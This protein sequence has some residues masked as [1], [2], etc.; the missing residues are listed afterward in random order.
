MD[1]ESL[2]QVGTNAGRSRWNGRLRAVRRGL[3]TI[4]RFQIEV[5]IIMALLVTFSATTYVITRDQ[6]QS[7]AWGSTVDMTIDVY[8]VIDLDE[9]GTPDQGTFTGTITYMI[10]DEQADDQSGTLL[11]LSAADGF[12]GTAT[13]SAPGSG[14][15]LH[16]DST[17]M[18][19]TDSSQVQHT[20]EAVW[21]TQLNSDDCDVVAGNDYDCGRLLLEFAEVEPWLVLTS[22]LVNRSAETGEDVLLLSSVR[23]ATRWDCNMSGI[24]PAPTYTVDFSDGSSAGPYD[25]PS[26]DGNEFDTTLRNVTFS[27]SGEKW[28]SQVTTTGLTMDNTTYADA[29]TM[30]ITD[31]SLL[32]GGATTWTARGAA[33]DLGGAVHTHVGHLTFGA[34]SE[35]TNGAVLL[36]GDINSGG[37]VV[38]PAVDF[39]GAGDWEDLDV[40]LAPG[41][42]ISVAA[43]KDLDCLRCHIRGGGGG[44]TSSS[45]GST[46]VPVLDIAGDLDL[47][48]STVTH[49]AG[50]AIVARSGSTGT[51][52]STQLHDVN[53]A[54][55][56]AVPGSL[57]GWTFTSTTAHNMSWLSITTDITTPSGLTALAGHELRSGVRLDQGMTVSSSATMSRTDIWCVGTGSINVTSGALLTLDDLS[58]KVCTGSTMFD[59]SATSAISMLDSRVTGERPAGTAGVGTAT[60]AVLVEDGGEATFDNV[61]F[62]AFEDAVVIV[63]EDGA[64]ITFGEDVHALDVAVA[65]AAGDGTCAPAATPVSVTGAIL[66]RVA[67]QA[68]GYDAAVEIESDCSLEWSGVLDIIGGAPGVLAQTGSDL[69][70]ETVIGDLADILVLLDGADTVDIG[71]LE[72]ENC[73]EAIRADADDVNIETLKTIWTDTAAVLHEGD[74]EVTM[75]DLD[76]ARIGIACGGSGSS[77]VEVTIDEIVGDASQSH[78]VADDGCDVNVD[79]RNEQWVRIAGWGCGGAWVRSGLDVGERGVP[80]HSR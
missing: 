32:S 15:R 38:P 22:R 28:I 5:A 1:A 45:W 10:E 52:S 76:H 78:I 48:Q 59:V 65:L 60:P 66:V 21:V 71:L 35:L 6:A 80:V 25:V 41:G 33:G 61:V 74:Y 7:F 58:A 75:M 46:V 31:G 73:A 34:G 19:Y 44:P 27:T 24:D 36:L 53:G 77:A 70:I 30:W 40:I 42:T 47:D 64:D 18:T 37:A 62:S 50:S 79:A 3:L 68:P 8:T 20:V 14:F 29:S 26:V 51:V 13:I 2:W 11:S 4:N 49:S 23:C 72:C 57:T 9:D 43:G 12:V 67:G 39:S 16:V 17:S 56:Y 55:L 63:A 54:A 69:D